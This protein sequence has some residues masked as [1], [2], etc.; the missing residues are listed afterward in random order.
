MIEGCMCV[1]ACIR[2]VNRF[3]RSHVGREACECSGAR[4]LHQ[5]QCWPW[6]YIKSPAKV[7]VTGRP[8]RI[9]PT[10]TGSGQPENN[11][12]KL[13]PTFRTL[14]KNTGRDREGGRGDA[15]LTPKISFLSGSLKEA[16]ERRE[17]VK[18]SILGRSRRTGKMSACQNMQLSA[19]ATHSCWWW[20]SRPNFGTLSGA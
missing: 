7:S 3:S 6:V 19:Q 5:S 4:I 2:R 1:S 20:Y 11:W 8:W 17:S 12:S 10:K 13:A 16:C 9:I 14:M 15:P 18:G